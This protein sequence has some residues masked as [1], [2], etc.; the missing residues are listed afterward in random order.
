MISINKEDG[1]RLLEDF[2]IDATKKDG[3]SKC[4]EESYRIM[5]SHDDTQLVLCALITNSMRYSGNIPESITKLEVSIL[6][7]LTTLFSDCETEEIPDELSDIF[8]GTQEEIF[9]KVS[10]SKKLHYATQAFVSAYL[11][12]DKFEKDYPVISKI[13]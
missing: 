12:F 11:H 6:S 5:R 7:A 8:S 3:S 1:D 10:L 9:E 13:L 4:A 2:L